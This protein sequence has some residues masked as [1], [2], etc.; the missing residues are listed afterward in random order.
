MIIIIIS[1][2]KKDKYLDLAGELKKLWNVKVLVILIV[3]G[4]RTRRFGNKKTSEDHPNYSIIK[5]NQNTKKSPRDL[6]RLAVGQKP[7]KNSQRSKIMVIIRTVSKC[8]RYSSKS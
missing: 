5:I 3:I 8:T 6:R 2:K 1:E 7:V 4:K